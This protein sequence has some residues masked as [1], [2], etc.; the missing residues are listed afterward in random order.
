VYEDFTWDRSD[1]MSGA[2]DDWVYEHLGLYGWTTEFWDPVRAATGSSMATHQWF[3]GPT[4]AEALA[5]LRWYDGR[6]VADHR[7]APFVDWYEF[8]HPQLGRVELGGWNHL[9]SWV[10]PPADL[11][12][13]EVAGHADFAI[14]QALASPRLEIVHHEVE[15]LGVDVWRVGVGIANTGWLPTTVTQHAA[16]LELVRPVVAEL[17]AEDAAVDVLD[18][19]ARRRVGQ[20]QGASAARFTRPDDGTPDRVLVVWTVRAPTDASITV[21]VDHPRAGRDAVDIT[22]RDRR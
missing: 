2:A 18:G 13:A 17:G 7:A 5:V 15:Q 12:R 10:N 14:A 1:P 3:L 8:D 6:P 21:S 9:Y 20:L 4:D 19:P 16:K 11:L 22:L